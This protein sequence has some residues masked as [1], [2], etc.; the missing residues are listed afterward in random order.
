ME[1]FIQ[2]NA[3][4]FTDL[5]A[6]ENRAWHPISFLIQHVKILKKS[7]DDISYLKIPY[8]I[9]IPGYGTRL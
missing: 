7:W 4:F 6:K 5:R 9:T 1:N 8:Q 3:I 2:T